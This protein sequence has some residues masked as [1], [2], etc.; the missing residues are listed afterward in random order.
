[1][2]AMRAAGVSEDF[3]EAGEVLGVIASTVSRLH[4]HHGT[5]DSSRSAGLVVT[6][7]ERLHA[8]QF[9]RKKQGFA[10]AKN[11]GQ[12]INGNFRLMERE[13]RHQCLIYEGSP[14]Q[15]LPSLAAMI[16][17]KLNEGHRCLYLNSRPMVSGIR[18]CLAAIGIDVANDVAK[19]RLVLSSE[20]A[21]VD[22]GFDVDMM[23]DKLEDAL[24]QSLSDGYAGL[25]ATGDMTWEFG[26][27]TN[28]ANHAKSAR[29]ER[30]LPV[31]SGYAASR[32]DTAGAADASNDLHQ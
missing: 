2:L 29:A 1:M 24:D 13:S 26:P 19:A 3:T 7:K 20:S 27:E 10:P 17:R 6:R 12:Q 23:L 18:S 32:S 21:I 28:F 16:Q 22:G 5:A 14:S 8:G 15:Q 11:P 4:I 30:N 9:H 31:P 25:W